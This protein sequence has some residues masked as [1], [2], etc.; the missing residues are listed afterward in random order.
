MKLLVLCELEATLLPICHIFSY[1]RLAVW[2]NDT[3]R[4]ETVLYHLAEQ[5]PYLSELQT[6]M[7]INH[8]ENVGP[9][10][11]VSL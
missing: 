9:V 11:F 3:V 2:M 8:R 10:E 6:K 7:D 4:S 1:S 5:N